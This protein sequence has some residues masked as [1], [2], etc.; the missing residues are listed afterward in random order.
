MADHERGR[1]IRDNSIVLDELNQECRNLILVMAACI[2]M[3]EHGMTIP[4]HGY[5]GNLDREGIKKEIENFIQ[6]RM[7]SLSGW[8]FFFNIIRE[9]LNKFDNK[10]KNKNSRFKSLLRIIDGKRLLERLK[11]KYKIEDDPRFH[12]ARKIREANRVPSEI[13][14][15]LSSLN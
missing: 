3:R 2:L 13:K 6:E 14:N 1:K 12:F 15:F 5:C 10:S 7:K 9:E 4:G 8:E 11:S